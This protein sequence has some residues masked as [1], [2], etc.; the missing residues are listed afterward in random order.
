[1]QDT[2][3]VSGGDIFLEHLTFVAKEDAEVMCVLGLRPSAHWWYLPNDPRWRDVM[4]DDPQTTFGMK[5]RHL[6]DEADAGKTNGGEV[7]GVFEILE[8]KCD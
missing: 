4:R 8:V 1:V 7:L 5:L 3:D 2:G 6:R